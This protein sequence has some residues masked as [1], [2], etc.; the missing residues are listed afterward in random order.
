MDDA[1][2]SA[3]LLPVDAAIAG[4]A[5]LQLAGA[6]LRAVVH[7]NPVTTG[8]AAAFAPGTLVRLHDGQRFIGVG[9]VTDGQVVAPRRLVGGAAGG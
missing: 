2:R 5:S 8:A 4:L 1:A 7:G 9:E 6:E 3:R